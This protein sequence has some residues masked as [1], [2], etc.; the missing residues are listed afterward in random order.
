VLLSKHLSLLAAHGPEPTRA[1][2]QRTILDSGV[3]PVMSDRATGCKGPGIAIPS[4]AWLL[5]LW[6]HI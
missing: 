6:S 5:R 1:L 4:A 3:R 2:L